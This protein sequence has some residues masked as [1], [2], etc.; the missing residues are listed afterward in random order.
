MEQKTIPSLIQSIRGG[1]ASMQTLTNAIRNTSLTDNGIVD[2]KT[3]TIADLS[4]LLPLLGGLCINS[5]GQMANAVT[6][7]ETM[8][9]DDM[10]SEDATRKPR[11]PDPRGV[12]GLIALLDALFDDT[13]NSGHESELLEELDAVLAKILNDSTATSVS[14]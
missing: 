10:G 6:T 8:E 13:E 12:A 11:I 9:R 1:V 3:S 5:S 4:T 7:D 2:A 14:H